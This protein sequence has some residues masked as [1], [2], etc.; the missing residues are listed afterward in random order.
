M[1]SGRPARKGRTSTR[2]RSAGSPPEAPR[3]R[4]EARRK[5]RS[6]RRCG[7]LRSPCS[8][9]SRRLLGR[10][11]PSSRTS[12]TRF[13]LWPIPFPRVRRR[14]HRPGSPA[15]GWAG[16]RAASSESPS[17]A[18]LARGSASSPRRRGTGPSPA[19]SRRGA[20]LTRSRHAGHGTVQAVR[21][22]SPRTS[23]AFPRT[24]TSTSRCSASRCSSGM[25]PASIRSTSPST[26][27]TTSLPAGSS[28]PSALP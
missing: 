18:F 26:G 5:S 8:T 21:R 2:S 16:R 13:S 14:T 4:R 3:R 20:S 17:R 11:R 12:W 24:T 27:S 15:P 25:A 9:R 28:P 23:T 6:H 1:S 19:G 22:A 10:S 7:R